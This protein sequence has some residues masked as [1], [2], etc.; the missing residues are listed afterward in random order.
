MENSNETK[1]LKNLIGK[2]FFFREATYHLLGRVKNVLANSFLEL[3]DAS[4]IPEGGP[5]SEFIKKGTMG[6]VQH[7]GAAFINIFSVTDFFPWEH[8]LPTN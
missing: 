2:K 5:F 4:W 3:E 8:D 1:D 6:E 7:V